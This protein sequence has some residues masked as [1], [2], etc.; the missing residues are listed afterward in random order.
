MAKT[1]GKRISHK[2]DVKRKRTV[3]VGIK[4][5]ME[6]EFVF[7]KKDLPVLKKAVQILEKA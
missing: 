6:L 7:T 2:K 5:N 3:A 4:D 1:K